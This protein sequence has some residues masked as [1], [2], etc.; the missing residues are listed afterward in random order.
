T[1]SRPLE[2]KHSIALKELLGA[3]TM[4][5]ADEDTYLSLANRLIRL[6]K[7]ITEK[8][9]QK[10]EEL[11]GGISLKQMTKDL[12]SAFDPDAVDALAQIE[13]NKIP[14]AERTPQNIADA[15]TEAQKSLIKTAS[16]NFNGELNNYIDNVR[17][18]H[19][20]I[21]DHKN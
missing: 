13:I 3:V 7:Q 14:E 15:K 11:S 16:L 21:I 2:R 18:Q 20:Q 4:G 9:N 19:E 10:L 12:I 8:E 6:E 17:K 5:I 1:D